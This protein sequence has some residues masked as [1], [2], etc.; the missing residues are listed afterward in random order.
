[1]DMSNRRP[2]LLEHAPQCA[3]TEPS[4]TFPVS[5]D[6]TLVAS[7]LR[8]DRKATAEFLFLHADP[9]YTCVRNRLIPRTDLVQD[10]FQDVFLAAW[11]GLAGFRG[12]SSLRSWLL[13]I[14][15]HKVENYY[16][17][18]RFF[19]KPGLLC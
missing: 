5:N 6:S 12:T 1:M 15:R 14:A 19:Q 2:D 13:G 18:K 17:L 4:T 8:Q 16:R 11:Q 9:V 10:V 7:V 3:G